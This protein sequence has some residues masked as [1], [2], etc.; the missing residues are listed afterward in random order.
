[1]GIKRVANVEKKIGLALGTSAAR[2]LALDQS[3]KKLMTLIDPSLPK[4][5]FIKGRKLRDLLGLF[6]G[7]DVEFSDLKIP[8]ACVATDVDTGEEIVI[9]QG[10]VLEAIRASISIPAIFT[11]VKWEGRHLVDGG[12]VNP[13]PVSV[14]RRMGTDFTIAV[15]VIPDVTVRTHRDKNPVESSKE[16]NILQVIVQSIY[17][18]TYSLVMSSLAGADIVIEPEVGQIGIGD[19]HQAQECI[20]QGELATQASLPKIKRLLENL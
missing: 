13:V 19:F 16:P 2:G 3:Q 14:L 10:S 12:L 18:A 11:V 6:I 8:L 17:I 20:R 7:S 4:T 5:G 9:D 1:M 15:N